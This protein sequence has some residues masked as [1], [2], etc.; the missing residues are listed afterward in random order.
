MAAVAAA[1]SYEIPEISEAQIPQLELVRS[2]SKQQREQPVY[3]GHVTWELVREPTGYNISCNVDGQALPIN[4]RS[5][6]Y[7]GL[8][9]MIYGMFG[10][11]EAHDSAIEHART[12]S[13]DVD[14]RSNSKW[15]GNVSDVPNERVRNREEREWAHNYIIQNQMKK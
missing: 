10:A 5:F 11:G 13:P 3:S 9:D 15:S 6:R 1:L 12:Y 7:K 14:F 4:S 2:T 8:V